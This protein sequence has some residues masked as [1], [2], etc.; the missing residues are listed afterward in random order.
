MTENNIDFSSDIKDFFQSLKKESNASFAE[1]IIDFLSFKTLDYNNKNPNFKISLSQI[2]EV[3]KRGV[4][5]AIRLEKPIGLWAAARVNL[6]LKMARGSVIPSSYKKL[7]RD[8]INDYSFFI[9]DGIR[10]DVIFNYEQISEARFELENFNLHKDQDYSFVELEEY[11]DASFPKVLKKSNIVKDL[12]LKEEKPSKYKSEEEEAKK[13][14]EKV[15]K[16][17]K[18]KYK[19]EE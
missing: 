12:A 8:I 15:L 17:T 9:D 19:E 6:F 10:D 16:E 14:K 1:K 11:T 2:K 4:S 7:D 13:G 18:T 3:Y 5:D